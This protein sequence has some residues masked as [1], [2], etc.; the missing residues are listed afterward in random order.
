MKGIAFINCFLCFIVNFFKDTNMY[1]YIYHKP[2]LIFF[3]I[4]YNNNSFDYLKFFIIKKIINH[5]HTHTHMHAHI[6]TYIYVC[7]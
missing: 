2:K 5:T 7:M 3:D 1:F 6:Y 4:Y